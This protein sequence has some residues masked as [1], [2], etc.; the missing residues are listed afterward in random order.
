MYGMIFHDF[1]DF[2]QKLTISLCKIVWKVQWCSW[3]LIFLAVS[4]IFLDIIWKIVILLH[5][6]KNTQLAVI[7]LKISPTDG[8]P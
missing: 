1:A 7:K 6:S 2:K 4:E 3:V 8:M 5:S